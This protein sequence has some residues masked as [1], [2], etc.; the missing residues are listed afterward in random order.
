[1]QRKMSA[2]FL[3][4]LIL[5]LPYLSIR[6]S[7]EC[8]TK[9]T[10]SYYTPVYTTL[11][12][13]KA[14]VSEQAPQD[15][16][17]PGK[18]YFIN[19]TLLVNEVG[20]GIHIFDN[21]DPAHPIAKA[22]L[23]IPGNLDLA[24]EGNTLYAD[25]YTD[26]VVF[27][28]TDLQKIKEIN[29]IEGLFRNYS[30]FGYGVDPVKGVVT[31]W[32][33]EQSVTITKSECDSPLQPWGGIYYSEGIGLLTNLSAADTP[34]VA[35][36]NSP[37][38]G[39]SM[40]RF[41]IAG[42][43]LYGLD[44]TDLD[45]VDISTPTHPVADSSLQVGWDAQTLFPANSHLFVGG[46]AGM[47]IFDLSVPE[48]PSLISQYDHIQSCD[49]VVVDGHF[50][51]V[52][53][54]SGDL[55]H[56]DTNE[57]QVIDIT[58]LT[59]PTLSMTYPMTNPHGLGINNSILFVCD[60]SS[61]LKIYDATDPLDIDTHLLAHYN[62]INVLDVIPINNVAML[63]GASGI[64]QYDYSDIHNIKLLSQIAIVKP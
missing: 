16:K 42:N 53:L 58:D 36:G 55:C 61:G 25:S 62:D 17:N 8:Q 28:I 13:L 64:Y 43:F 6:C 34:M 10:F 29:R 52:T 59:N 4:G 45:V 41:T 15:I 19:G 12:V 31:S 20:E 32:A 21:H 3:A 11:A 47:Y 63:I 40:A 14:A 60:G 38:V 23:V 26:L 33:K 44:G 22:F 7:D 39:G 24:V 56:V 49:P 2:C 37:G 30:S 48:R 46:R 50:A 35:P 5:F 27:D 54:Y 51:Y 18:I 1:M 9:N 57:L